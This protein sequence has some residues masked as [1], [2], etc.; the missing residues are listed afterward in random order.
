MQRFRFIKSKG[1]TSS[2]GRQRGDFL[3]ES[4][5]GLVLAAIIGLGVIQVTSRV[6]VSQHDMRMQEIAI[7]QMRAALIRNG[8]GAL[9][10]CK[11]DF[12]IILPNDEEVEITLHG[13]DEF[14]TAQIHGK[15]VPGIRKPI[16]ISAKAKSFD[17]IMVGGTWE[18]VK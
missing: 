7:N 4:M 10:I 16:F 12:T 6:S 15:E 2:P 17:Q 13:C 14:A 5:I 1:V 3:I 9:D 8:M 18:M 11:D